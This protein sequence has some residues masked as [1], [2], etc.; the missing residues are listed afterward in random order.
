MGLAGRKAEVLSLPELDPVLP[1]ASPPSARLPTARPCPGNQGFS[2]NQCRGIKSSVKCCL[3][4]GAAGC[5]L[6]PGRG[7]WP[8]STPHSSARAATLRNL[9]SGPGR[10]TEL[11]AWQMDARASVWLIRNGI[12]MPDGKLTITLYRWL[13]PSPP[14]LPLGLLA[15]HGLKRGTWVL[16]Y[17]HSQGWSSG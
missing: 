13:C 14:P 6:D 17:P 11:A 5:P 3:V 8:G 9:P 12:R 10:F 16:Q 1:E 15:P 4:C 2:A 7:A